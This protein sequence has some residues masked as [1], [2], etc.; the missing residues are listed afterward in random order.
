MDGDFKDLGA[1]NPSDFPLPKDN[2]VEGEPENLEPFAVAIREVKIVG[3]WERVELDRGDAQH[4]VV[5][6]DK[7]G[8]QVCIFVGMN[9][10]YAVSQSLEGEKRERPMTYDLLNQIITRLGATVDQVVIDDIWQDTFYAKLWLS[11]GVNSMDI[12]CRPSDAIN[13]AIRAKA[14]IYMAEHVI[15]ACAKVN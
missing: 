9:E 1:W 10:A 13:V 3:A 14:P 2:A 4:F 5:L 15:E 8:R 11:I 6:E 7:D 12:D